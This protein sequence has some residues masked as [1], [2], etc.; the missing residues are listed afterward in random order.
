M[1]SKHLLSWFCVLAAL[2]VATGCTSDDN[3]TKTPALEIVSFLASTPEVGAGLPVQLSWQTRHASRIEIT[4]VDGEALYLGGH[5]PERGDIEV[6]PLVDT[7]WELRAFDT[8][9]SSITSLV[10]VHVV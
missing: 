4:E 8:A 6:R 7:T 5:Q 10:S 2:L 1:K 9:G 3:K